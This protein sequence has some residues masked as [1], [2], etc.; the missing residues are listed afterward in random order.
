MLLHI[1]EQ[2][3][4]FV[5]VSCST[6]SADTAKMLILNYVSFSC[7]MMIIATGASYRRQRWAITSAPKYEP[8]VTTRKQ[9]EL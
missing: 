7:F 5:R 4:A 3:L 2:S 1:T 8:D 9:N 6:I